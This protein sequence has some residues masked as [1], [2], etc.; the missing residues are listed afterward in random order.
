MSGIHLEI[1]IC[2]LIVF[3]M[4]FFYSDLANQGEN[5][6]Q[7][8]FELTIMELNHDIHLKPSDQHLKNGNI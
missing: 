8:F 6:F 3:V 4:C 7:H 1:L 2:V 5:I